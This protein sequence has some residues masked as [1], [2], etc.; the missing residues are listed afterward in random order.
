MTEL[1]STQAQLLEWFADNGRDLPWRRTRNPY[2]ILVAEIML[3]QTQVDRVMPKYAAFLELFPTVEAL[4]AASTAEVIRSWQGLGYNRR[5]VNLQRAAQALVAA[6]YPAAPEAFPRTPEGLRALPG[7]G[8]YTA[9]AVAC[10]AFERD[11]AFLDTNIRRVVRRLRVGP[12]DQPP[13]TSE[14]QLTALAAELVP[15][16]RGWAWN[17]AIMELGALICTAARPQCWRCPLRE[18][19]AAYATW[20]AADTNLLFAPPTPKLRRKAAEQ[21]FHSSNRYFRGRVIEALR[22]LA[23]HEA[24]TLAQLGPLVKDGWTESELAWLA[25]LATGLANDGLLIWRDQPR[26]DLALW[27]VALPG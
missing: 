10:F 16:G 12:E 4:A 19:C 1:S 14:A 2:Q 9:G 17:Q 15:A 18:R 13:E 11:V 21:P 6:G 24:H 3:Q 22:Q 20:S 26:D 7:I 27:S 5:A 25:K 23:D 8:A